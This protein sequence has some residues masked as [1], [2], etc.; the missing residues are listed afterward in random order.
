MIFRLCF[1][2]AAHS[3]PLAALVVANQFAHPQLNVTDL[4]ALALVLL[5]EAVR[6]VTVRDQ[7]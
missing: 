4:L 6:L 7:H 5:F 3:L 1:L 2:R